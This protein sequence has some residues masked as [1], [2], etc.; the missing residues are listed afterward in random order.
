MLLCIKKIFSGLLCLLHDFF[1]LNKPNYPKIITQNFMN[2][3]P[4][5]SGGDVS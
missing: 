4:T 3:C 2:S 1:L 5:T